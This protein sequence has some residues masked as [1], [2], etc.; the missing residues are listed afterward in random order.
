MTD[1]EYILQQARKA[2]YSGWDDAELRKC[3]DMLEGLSREQLFALYSSRWMKD[4]KILKDEIF[5]RLFAEQLGKREERIK[6]L[7]TEELI[8]EFRDKK[9][10]NVSLI[11]NEMKCRYKENN[12]DDRIKITMAF[13]E[14]SAGDQSWVEHQER[15]NEASGDYKMQNAGV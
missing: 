12:G 5:R 11:R 13:K 6:N 1:Y 14:S 4:A 2:H 9:S 7:S 15:K 10:G 8:E 3:V